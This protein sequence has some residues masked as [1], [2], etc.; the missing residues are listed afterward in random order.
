MAESAIRWTLLSGVSG[1]VFFYRS[2]SGTPGSWTLLNPDTPQ[3]GTSGEFLDTGFTGNF[4][5]PVY[6]CGMV[7]PGGPPETWLKGLPVTALDSLT[8]REYFLT[9][10]ILRREYTMMLRHNGLPAFHLVTKE[11]GTA[12][13][14]TDGQTLQVLGPSCAG[15][16]Q[17]GFTGPWA[18]GFYPPVQTVAMIMAMGPVDRKTRP[19]ATGDNPDLSVVL[20]LLTFPTPARGHLIVFPKSDRRYVLADPIKPFYLRGASPVVW[21]AP[22]LLLNRDD[23]RMRIAIPDLL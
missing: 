21:E 5:R 13:S 10:E 7:D 14:H 18:G 6:Y 11:K 9:R 2:E 8:R 15:D 4:L 16:P 20:R 1:D 12:A 19:D 17:A 3:T 22:A 23:E